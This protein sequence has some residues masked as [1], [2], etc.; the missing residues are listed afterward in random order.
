MSYI[1]FSIVA[2][3]HALCGMPFALEVNIVNNVSQ[4]TRRGLETGLYRAP[5][6]SSILLMRERAGDRATSPLRQRSTLPSE[7]LCNLGHNVPQTHVT[8]KIDGVRD[9][10]GQKIDAV[11]TD[12]AAHRADTE[13]H[14]IDYKIS[15]N[16]D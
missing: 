9:E 11:A 13:I 5:R 12:L 15:E 14:R 16:R 4:N 1:A 2:M 7:I 6:Q 3:L 10:L 8:R